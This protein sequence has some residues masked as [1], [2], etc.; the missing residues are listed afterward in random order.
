MFRA[1]KTL[2]QQLHLIICAFDSFIDS[3]TYFKPLIHF[4]KLQLGKDLFGQ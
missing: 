2:R 4:Q 1:I 3:N